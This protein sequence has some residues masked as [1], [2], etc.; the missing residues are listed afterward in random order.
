MKAYLLLLLCIWLSSN[1]YGAT[2]VS[3]RQVTGCI[4]DKGTGTPIEFAD[5][6]VYKADDHTFVTGTVSNINGRFY[7]PS[8]PAGKYYIVYSFIGYK[9]Q[10][11][12]V[13]SCTDKSDTNL[14]KIYIAPFTEQ[15]NEVVVQ[16]K[17]STYVQH[18]DKRVFNVGTDLASTSGSVSDLMRNIP[19]VQVD[20]EGNVSLR[21]NESVTVLI[22]G[23]P[24]TLMNTRTRA[25]ALR[26]IPADEIERIEVITNPS[27]QYKPDGVSGIINIV[28][29]KQMMKGLN[30]SVTANAGTKGRRNATVS[31]NYNTGKVNLF[32]SYGIRQDNYEI[33][34]TDERTKRDS[35][36]AYISQLTTGRAHPL[37]NIVRVG[38][39]WNINK[40]NHLQVNGGYNY[41]HF[42]RKE[43][44]YDTEKSN[45]YDITYQSVRY[46]YDNEHTKQWEGGGLYTHTFGKGHE[47]TVDYNYS[48]LEGLEDNRYSTYSTDG[49]SKDNTQ[50]WQAYYQH[51]FRLT[52][53]K[54]F[55]DKLKLSLGYE[56]DALQ[57]DLNYHV[58]NMTDSTFV[59]DLQKTNDF[60]NYQH[61]HAW[62][63][64]LEYRQNKWGVFIGLRPEWMQIK[65]QLLR[66]DSIVRN[67]YFMVYPTL[68]TSYTIDEQNELQLN[69]SLR[70]N[71]PEADDMNPFPEYQNPLSLKAG[72]PYLKPEK[73]HSVEV[74]YQWKK[75]PTT[76][77]GTLY[78]R[79]V[80]DKLTMIT[81]Y[82]DNNVLLTTK[83]NLNSSSSA[84]AELIVNSG[85]GKWG[86]VNLSGNLFYDR[87]NA[88]RLGYGRNKNSVAGSMA[89]NANF[90]VYQGIM[91]QLNSRYLSPTLLPQ[92]KR[93]G[94]FSTDLG[95][96][97]EIPSINLSLTAT[98]SDVFNT[99]KKVYTIDTPQLQ[100]HLEQ[101]S[102]TQVFYVGLAWKFNTL[103]K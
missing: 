23:K 17:R 79:Y 92:G 90:N 32:A 27:A 86:E 54:A 69:Y 25:D 28:R 10:Q 6:S 53:H 26:Q 73:I 8:L 81:K 57:T 78:Y 19:S 38:A 11:T 74:G 36:I 84:G 39:D 95:I 72:N 76:I 103:K 48:M 66:L 101:Q 41:R 20:V 60:T 5:I 40:L 3:E 55:S 14:G 30:G 94:T 45:L 47:L 7:I 85:L 70:V 87:I 68:H 35:T 4:L 12:P 99:F 16:G 15:L 100:Q 43:N 44:F 75:G 56:L 49:D 29:K 42:V 96:K 98:L 89:L 37:S 82:L 64:T 9:K 63:A 102:N 31:V 97:Y 80:T 51:L 83:E 65:S 34:T 18:I 52:Y 88:E 1:I 61:N 13:F 21:G 50:I 93:E 24:S 67:D 46:R 58:Q 71:R 62:Y 33:R 22:D 59:P 2:Y 91:L 77:L